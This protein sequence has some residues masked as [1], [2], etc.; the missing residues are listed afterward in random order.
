MRLLTLLVICTVTTLV[1]VV[2]ASAQVLGTFR[3]R[4]APYCNQLSLRIEQ[5]GTI[6]ELSGTDDQCGGTVAAAA[7]G[8]AHLNPNGTIGISLVVIRPDGIPIATSA[9]ISQST[10]S[11]SWSDEY[12]NGGSLTFNPTAAPGDPR[13]VTL[14]GAYLVAFTAVAQ[15]NPGATA[16]AFGRRAPDSLSPTVL[17]LGQVST[18]DCPGN[19]D[20]PKAAPGKLCVYEGNSQNVG[21]LFVAN[22]TGLLGSTDN[23]G[24]SVVAFANAAGL[25]GSAGRW[26]VTLP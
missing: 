12:G 25:V 7:N 21:Q 1:N 16:I 13:R 9:S 10:L 15:N 3:W 2:P 24:G 8:S 23:S 14:T 19:I 18:V 11:G 20:D 4:L 22:G 17:R 5:K 26:A 6:F